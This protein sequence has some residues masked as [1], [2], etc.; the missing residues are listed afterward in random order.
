M[1]HQFIPVRKSDIVEGLT[2]ETTL[3]GAPDP[4][5]FAQFCRLLGLTIHYEFFDELEA[6]K[7]AYFHFNPRLAT[8]AKQTEAAYA[9]LV[10]ALRKILERANFVEV[11]PEEIARAERERGEMPVEVRSPADAYRDV[12]MFKRGG[13]RESVEVSEWFG[14]R[15]HHVEA[16]V[17]D[18]VVL[19][20]VATAAP[21][22]PAAKHRRHHRPTNGAVLIKH[23]HDIASADLNT[24]LPDVHVIMN[25]R[26]RWTL[27]LPALIG[28]VPLI[29]KLA[30]TLAVLF[31]L[32]GVQLGYT[33]TVEQ[34]HLKQALA[35]MSG[36]IALGSFGAH[37]WL[38]YQ[39]KALRYL[40]AIKDSIYFRNVN[41]N[42][43]VFDALVGAAEEQEFKEA[44][45]AYRFLLAEPADADSL[46][47]RVEV[48]LK[49][50]FGVDVDFE[51]DDG[52]AKLERYGLLTRAGN[53]LSVPPIAEALH[54]LDERWDQY[55][56]YDKPAA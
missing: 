16:E 44:V 53:R 34:D 43:G 41:N 19:V 1:R 52:L 20:A 6:L 42:A 17:Y 25:K 46:D 47:G 37:Q 51:V 28:G 33:G 36:V 13:H 4:Q 50:K 22:T 38:K 40:V 56:S 26:D 15:R 8:G 32:A 7:A 3:A 12:S 27:G 30:P 9:E 29:L 2:A 31:L 39:R 10:A 23:F 5:S 49:A 55:F 24:L 21:G 54:R 11:P 35:V 18:D 45:L 14:L 48:W